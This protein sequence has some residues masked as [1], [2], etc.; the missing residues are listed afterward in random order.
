M[1]T[2][3]RVFAA[4]ARTTSSNSDSVVEMLS[5][6][7][8]LSAALGALGDQHSQETISW[9]LDELHKRKLT[10]LDV[11]ESLHRNGLLP[12]LAE[13]IKKSSILPVSI[14]GG[15]GGGGEAA[16]EYDDWT[17]AS[18]RMD[19]LKDFL[20]NIEHLANQGGLDLDNKAIFA[21]TLSS[22]R[23]SELSFLE[24]C[25]ILNTLY[26]LLFDEAPTVDQIKDL[27][28]TLVLISGLVL[29]GS[30]G[31]FGAAGFSDMQDAIKRH[32]DPTDI[33]WSFCSKSALTNYVQPSLDRCQ[34]VLNP[35]NSY[36]NN[37]ASEKSTY[38]AGWALALI[39][40]FSFYAVISIFSL[41]LSSVFSV[42]CYLFI[43]TTSFSLDGKQ[44]DGAESV[45]LVQAW[46]LF[47]RWIILVSFVLWV[48]GTLAT[49]WAYA[50]LA[51]IKFPSLAIELSPY[52]WQH[53]SAATTGVAATSNYGIAALIFWFGLWT[54]FSLGLANKY[55]IKRILLKRQKIVRDRVSTSRKAAVGPVLI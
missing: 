10:D 43:T 12:A 26:D 40:G 48:L 9:L 36:P 19:L 20:E 23:S 3:S 42:G 2:S 41:A 18:K 50:T 51:Y 30:A 13:D 11:V 22:F 45:H 35:D 33:S 15:G 5:S 34:A 44:S 38:G 21:L 53:G 54:L 49:G 52:F 31:L 47:V 16:G 37:Y 17:E 29:G 8:E 6:S 28:Q 24:W 14:G 39:D 25:P 4:V 27:L 1:A 55:R 46:W 7:K 32:S